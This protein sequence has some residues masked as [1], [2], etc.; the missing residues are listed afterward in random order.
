MGKKK[1][2]DGLLINKILLFA[3]SLDIDVRPGKKHPHIMNFYGMRPCPVASSTDAKKMIVPWIK[4]ITGYNSSTVY[5]GL[6][7]GKLR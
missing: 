1:T 5:N 3:E 4:E 7:N 6:R 2:S